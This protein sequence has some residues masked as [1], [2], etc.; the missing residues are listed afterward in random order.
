[1]LITRSDFIITTIKSL[2]GLTQYLN[3]V[4]TT[5]K[6]VLKMMHTK[7]GTHYPKTFTRSCR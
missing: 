3:A 6:A 1:M 5:A 7:T 2:A 4:L